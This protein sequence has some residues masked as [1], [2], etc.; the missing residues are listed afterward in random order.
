MII[1]YQDNQDCMLAANIIYN[2]KNR[3]C[4]DTGKDFIMNYRYSQTDITELSDKDQTVFIIGVGFFKDNPKSTSRLISLIE[5]SKKV[6]W[7]S[8]HEY[9]K[10]L[11][12]SEY[13]SK[14]NGKLDVWYSENKSASWIVHYSILE[15][16]SNRVVDLVGEFQTTRNPSRVATNLYLFIMTVF[17]SPIDEIWNQIYSKP[18]LIDELLNTG[19]NIYHFIVH[20]NISCFDKRSYD[21][22]F[23]GVEFIVINGNYKIFLPEIIE[24]QDKP[25][26]L[27][28]YNGSRYF[29]V[30]YSAKSDL[31]CLEFTKEFNGHGKRYRT[32]V[33]SEVPLI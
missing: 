32:V 7:I 21:R 10:D 20:Q 13:Y 8:G 22:T 16:D 17:S 23:K 5:S 24:K 18:N 31:D 4:D 26:I 6:I 33:V 12:N 14:Y 25:V 27:W 2:N 30:I 28:Y 9:T 3:F 19:S 1:Y 11:L 15:G 29:Y